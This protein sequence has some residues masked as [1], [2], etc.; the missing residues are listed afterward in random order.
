MILYSSTRLCVADGRRMAEG[1]KFCRSNSGQDRAI[2][3][4]LSEGGVVAAVNF[5]GARLDEPDW[6]L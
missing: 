5:G 2:Q 3:G 1:Y 6:V 4:A